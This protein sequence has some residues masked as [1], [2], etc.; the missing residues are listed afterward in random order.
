MTSPKGS[1]ICSQA[2]SNGVN[3]IPGLE[4][5]AAREQK[6]F[7]RLVFQ[8]LGLYEAGLAALKQDRAAR[9][10]ANHCDAETGSTE[11]NSRT[12]DISS[13]RSEDLTR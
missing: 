4:R 7:Q 3:Y 9:N 12:L 13:L 2:L 6:A 5:H 10:Q 8:K 1:F 11:V